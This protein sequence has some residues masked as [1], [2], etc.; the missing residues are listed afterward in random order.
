MELQNDLLS[1]IKDAPVFPILKEELKLLSLVVREL[2]LSS[3]SDSSFL[4]RNDDD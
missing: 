2:H 4:S 3:C 1:S